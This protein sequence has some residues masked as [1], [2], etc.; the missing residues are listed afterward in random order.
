MRLFLSFL[1]CNFVVFHVFSDGQISGEVSSK[2]TGRSLAG[3][4][5]SIDELSFE[6]TADSEGDFSFEEVPSGTYELT[7]KYLG[8]QT[9]T[10]EISIED[11]E[12]TSLT[13]ELVDTIENMVVYG[14]A[15]STAAAL[16]Q[17][18]AADIVS[19]VLSSDDFGQLPDANLSEALQR[20]PGVFL[21]RDQGE[22]RFV[23][24]RG[25]DPGLNA[26][27]INGVT[28]TAPESETRAVALD[29]IP[30]ELLETLIVK[31]TFTPDMEPE[32]VGGSIEVKSFS[33]FDRKGSSF[34]FK[35]E[36]NHNQLEG[37]ASPKLS[38]RF[39]NRMGVFEG[40]DNFG[41]AAAVSWYDRDFGSENVE[42]D[43]GWFA[44]LE[45]EDGNEFKGAE[46]IEQRNYEI[47]RIR[48]GAALNLDYHPA[49]DSEY[50]LRLLFSEFSDREYRNRTEYKFD[51]GDAIV[52]TDTSAYWEDAN[53]ERSLKDRLETQQILSLVAGGERKLFDWDV[54]YSIGLSQSGE[55]EPGRI[56]TTF[57][58]KNVDLGYDTIGNVPELIA[59]PE[60]NDPKE[61]EL[62]EIVT[63][64]NTT[65]D[66]QFS[67]QTDWERSFDFAHSKATL[68]VGGKLRRRE[69]ENDL[70]IAIY[71]G[72]PGDPT[73]TAFVQSGISYA[74]GDFG[75]AL[76]AGK[77]NDYINS[78]KHQFER[79]YEDTSISS[80]V[81]DYI[82]QEDVNAFYLMSKYS[83]EQLRIV[84]GVRMEWTSFT[85][86]GQSVIFD[87]VVGD[88]D[89][90]FNG[91]DGEVEYSNLLPSVNARYSFSDH[92]ILRGAYYQTI[93]R[94][95]FGDLS[96]GGEIEFEED[97]GETEF[98]AELGNPSLDPLTA[99][100]FDV[101]LEYYDVGIGLLAGGFFHKQISDFFV[102]ADVADITD[103][104]QFV[105][106]ATVDDAELISPINGDSATITG[107][108]VTWTKKFNELPAPWNGLL[109]ASNLTISD[110]E[111]TLAL[112]DSA[113]PMPKQSD[114]VF[115]L[116]IGYETNK[117]SFRFAVTSKSEALVALED[118]EDS[119]FDVYQSAHTQYDFSVKY[120]P[121]ERWLI[122][123]DGNNLT[124]EPMYRYFK[125]SDYN[126]QYEEY[127][128]TFAFGWQYRL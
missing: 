57:K 33:A 124:E 78:N 64:D 88:G 83:R 20:M 84:Y 26:T 95:S 74:L 50:Y 91:V 24:I 125:G 42:T 93:A 67:V 29:V 116:S 31:K 68:K 22:G 118:F 71:S 72:F 11:D 100:N 85:A 90:V 30:S 66:D 34:R 99:T 89:P 73:M 3:A 107:V 110:S 94:P 58:L 12:T 9:F 62:D 17:Q 48:V 87:A 32:G 103:L 77:I 2:D 53:L 15:S 128:K 39:S 119:E 122:Y 23:G 28:L 109:L 115:N 113:I 75:P 112:R 98:K 27:S 123:L 79:D 106:G 59:G 44:D 41:I 56:D 96:P 43:G 18:R 70:E 21:E 14:Q 45:T 40:K 1:V 80:S 63:E 117:L 108:E 47:N 38:A 7:V 19:S 81:G 36:L 35:S 65:S 61:F 104:S 25:I 126:A 5:V 37:T 120:Y 46:E 10:E 97:D 69:K 4:I 102:Y 105:G 51:K 82:M 101:S 92:L 54:E 114:T 52:G 13:V 111:A 6:T 121:A 16:N 49:D 127:G 8:F 86:S 55:D 76:D 60:A